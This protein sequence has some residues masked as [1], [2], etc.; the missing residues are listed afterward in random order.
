MVTTTD[1]G[2]V[3][4]TAVPLAGGPAVR[5]FTVPSPGRDWTATA[6]LV[7]SD[8]LSALLVMVDDP[9][10]NLRLSRVYAGP[11]SGPLA[12]VRQVRRP[13]R[14]TVWFPFGVDV[15]A[16]RL[17]IEE[18]RQP[19]LALRFAVHAPG[20]VPVR[21]R[22]GPASSY[23]ALAGDLVAYVRLRRGAAPSFRVVD[24][25]T[26]DVRGSIALGE[27]SEDM[28][29]R[30][31]D[32]T[33]DGR[34]VAVLDGRLVGASPGETLRVLPGA[35]GGARFSTPL[36]A[37]DRVA[38]L[39]GGPF[40]SYRPVI[41]DP[42]SGTRRAVGSPSTELNG[43]AVDERTVAW[44]SN[45]CVVATG[46]DDPGSLD[47]LPPGPCP[48]AEVVLEEGDQ[49]VRGGRL[50]VKVFCVAAPPSGCRGTAL[51]GR[52]GWVGRQ[53]F[54]VPPGERR[55]IRVPVSQRG[56]RAIRRQLRR[57]GPPVYGL[58][59]RMPDGR[60]GRGHRTTGI[61]VWRIR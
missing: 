56:M 14:G 33:E 38:V 57:G 19:D 25:R 54:S 30:D 35:E 2:G 37:G 16:D 10:G 60:V 44:L 36:F 11:P 53:R 48:R 9:E 26:G 43:L 23:T 12:L 21:R 52:G 59:A 34:V 4:V 22:Q 55:R 39:A 29:G 7:S 24:W 5:R 28:H 20:A 6:R 32:L 8:R 13:R 61:L 15:H 1:H 41:V 58:G 3:R 31:L 45:G 49:A 47:A 51:I 18:V 40:D 17:L 42:A 27:Y 46:L 50:Q